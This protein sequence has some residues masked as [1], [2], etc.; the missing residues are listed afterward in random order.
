MLVIASAP[1]LTAAQFR[2]IEMKM[3]EILDWQLTPPTHFDWVCLYFRMGASKYP[4]EFRAR[5]IPVKN[6]AGK[7][8]L[9]CVANE[10]LMDRKPNAFRKDFF[11]PAVELIDILV[12]RK[13]SLNFN[14]SVSVAAAFYVS[15]ICRF[16]E[17]VR[18]EMFE[19]CTQ[20]K[21]DQLG[22]CLAFVTQVYQQQTFY[23]NAFYSERLT[24]SADRMF[25]QPSYDDLPNYILHYDVSDFLI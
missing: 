19:V 1:L 13:E 14:P 24:N 6:V 11:V 9:A 21:L 17:S 23:P 25:H 12:H 18:E 2:S 8:P 4:E 7:P 15:V 5:S 3:V 22:E 10:K 20:Y 16:R